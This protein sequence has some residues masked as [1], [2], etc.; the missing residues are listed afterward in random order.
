MPA[1]PTLGEF[2]YF[3]VTPNW[4]LDIQGSQKEVTKSH[5]LVLPPYWAESIHPSP[6][7]CKQKH[8]GPYHMVGANCTITN[9]TRPISHPNNPQNKTKLW[10]KLADSYMVCFVL[11]CYFTLFCFYVYGVLEGMC[12]SWISLPCGFFFP[13]LFSLSTP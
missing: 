12:C 6:G 10:L 7:D 8:K 2:L 5:F 9:P 13:P 4:Y 1:H 3:P 11:L